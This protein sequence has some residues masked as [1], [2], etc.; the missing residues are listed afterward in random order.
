[1]PRRKEKVLGR[2]WNKLTMSTGC[3]GAKSVSE[4]QY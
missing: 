3:M 1:M 4:Y 2:F